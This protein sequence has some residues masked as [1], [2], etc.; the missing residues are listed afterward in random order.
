MNP[1]HMV[2]KI[3]PARESISGN[4]SITSFKEAKMGVISVAMESMSLPL[5]S[6]K[7]SIGRK[8]QLGIQ[9]GRHFAAIWFQVR[10][11]VF[12]VQ[13]STST[14]DVE[15]LSLTGRRIFE[16]LGDGYKVFLHWKRDNN[17]SHHFGLA[18]HSKDGPGGFSFQCPW[19]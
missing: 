14:K 5:M 16:L 13:V 9:A 12:A 1:P 19:T 10:I 3:P 6:E 7:A 15:E 8:L 17:I 4:R 18:R 2:E 11:Q